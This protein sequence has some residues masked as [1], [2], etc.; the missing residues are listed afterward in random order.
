MRRRDFLRTS[1]AGVLGAAF[2]VLPVPPQLE[3]IEGIPLT[4]LFGTVPR[5]GLY[6]SIITTTTTD[7]GPDLIWSRQGR[8]HGRHL[9]DDGIPLRYLAPPAPDRLPS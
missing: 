4:L 6:G 9:Q 1:L 3:A 7:W 2:G 8:V 5:H